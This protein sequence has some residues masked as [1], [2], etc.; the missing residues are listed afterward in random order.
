MNAVVN[1]SVFTKERVQLQFLATI[2]GNKQF[3]GQCLT[4]ANC[5]FRRILSSSRMREMRRQP[6]VPE[7]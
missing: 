4:G 3:N 6:E 7:G 2:V 1:E 5:R